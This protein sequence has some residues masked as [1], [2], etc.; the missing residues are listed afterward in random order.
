MNTAIESFPSNIIA[1]MF[2]FERYTMYE[3]DDVAQRQNV[4]V[5]FGT[6]APEAPAAPAPAPEAPAA[7]APEAP[8]APAPEAPAAPAPEAPAAPDTPKE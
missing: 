8:A 4:T 6:A 5:D 2:H 7:P 3:M 1:N